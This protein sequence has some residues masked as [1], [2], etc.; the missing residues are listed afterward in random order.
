[1]TDPDPTRDRA[2]GRST[3]LTDPGFRR[4]L[5]LVLAV[6]LLA[7]IGLLIWAVA[8]RRD[9]DGRPFRFEDGQLTGVQSER[10]DVMARAEQFMLRF[11]TYG[12]DLLEGK[13]MP[14]Y[15]KRVKELITPKYATEFDQLVTIPEQ[16]VVKYKVKQTCEIF[17]AGVA[18]LD[19]D[20]ATAL[21]SGSF[22]SQVGKEPA[23]PAQ[24]F[25]VEVKLVKVKGEWLVD[26]FEPVAGAAS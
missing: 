14:E 11:N 2:S 24:A 26:D 16:Q 4:I 9:A 5:A 17:G 21:V 25:R 12:P 10:E 22:T 15:T 3:A 1:M 19:S 18:T 20:S 7:S 6:L 13:K 8:D 23:Q